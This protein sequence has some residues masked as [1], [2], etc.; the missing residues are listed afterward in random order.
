[1]FRPRGVTPTRGEGRDGVSPI[2]D[3][4][5]LLGRTPPP[6]RGGA[7]DADRLLGR[8]TPASEP[9]RPTADSDRLLGRGGRGAV[10]PAVDPLRL[11]GLG[12]GREVPGV[13]D[14][15]DKDRGGGDRDR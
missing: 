4:D 15:P 8:G 1:M 7:A 9:E 11:L 3:V 13:T 5:R 14:G 10:P 6:E 12:G 2:R